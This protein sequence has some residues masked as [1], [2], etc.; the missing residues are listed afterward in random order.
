MRSKVF[1]KILDKA[2]NNPWYI[3]LK[4]WL[5]INIWVYSCLI[6]KYWDK[7]YNKKQSGDVGVPTV[8]GVM[9]I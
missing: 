6:R 5:V 3:K 4:C 2:E 1:Q 9:E 8:V 7:D